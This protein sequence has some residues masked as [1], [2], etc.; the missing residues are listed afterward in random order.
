MR[1]TAATEPI[2]VIM[3]TAAR[4]ERAASLL[5]AINTVVSQQGVH[6][7]PVV[8][9]N[10]TSQSKA[11]LAHLSGRRDIRLVRFEEPSLPRAL[12][13]GRAT[14]DT[15]F[16]AVLDDDDELLPGG[17]AA[18][19]RGIQNT[20]ATDVV[21][22]N[23]YFRGGDG[24][25]L[26]ISDFGVIQADPLRALI[27]V[28][29]LTP[30]AALFRTETVTSE[31]FEDIP[32]YLEWTHMA[33]HLALRRRILFIDRPTFVYQ[34]DTPNSLSKTREYILGQPQAI[35]QL[36]RLKLPADVE[37]LLKA[38]LAGALH[39]A[40]EQA[41]CEGAHLKAW[42]WHIRCLAR[43]EGWR[44]LLYTRHLVVPVR[45]KRLQPPTTR[46]DGNPRST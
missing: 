25:A 44:Y 14:V 5:R 6:G 36:L 30:C 1:D 7:L 31:F 19:L 37:S 18:R 15:R 20:P 35:Q 42:L 21:V 45:R 22:T 43:I 28:N 9:V 41:L 13:V 10:G 34:T 3:P 12:Q 17:L 8:V 29:W 27:R 38:R 24:E 23:G 16:F 33:M 26:N 4:P 32:R 39:A 2:S 40:S 46:F 11:L